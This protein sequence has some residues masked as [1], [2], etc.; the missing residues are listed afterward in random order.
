[1]TTQSKVAFENAISKGYLTATLDKT[2]SYTYAGNWMYMS[3]KNCGDQ[4]P[5]MVDLFKNID[6]REYMQVPA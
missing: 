6:T 1:M 4:V 3:T 5:E 2:D